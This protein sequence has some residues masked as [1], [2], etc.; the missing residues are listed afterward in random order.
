[1]QQIHYLFNN[2]ACVQTGD[3]RQGDNI[4]EREK[5]ARESESQAILNIITPV[6][7]VFS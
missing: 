5:Y 3:V 7:P 4:R 1:M 2:S 6:R